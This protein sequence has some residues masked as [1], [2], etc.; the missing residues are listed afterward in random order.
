M[1]N[2]LVILDA[3]V[4]LIFPE[5]L[6]FDF[7]TSRRSYKRAFADQPVDPAT[8]EKLVDVA[9]FAPSA[10]NAQPWH[11]IAVLDADLRQKLAKAMGERFRKDLTQDGVPPREVS[12]RIHHSILTFSNA[13]ALVV[14]CGCTECT[15]DAYPDGPRQLAEGI[16]FTQSVANATCYFLLAA[17]AHGLATS[18]Y[19][20]PLFA[21]ETVREVL[22]LL[23]T[24]EPQAFVTLGYPCG[25]LPAAPP[26]KDASEIL[27]IM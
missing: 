7:L 4:F 6:G 10:H 9:Q 18:W 21:K 26:R 14:I 19:C 8:I 1:K 20:A 22:K 3:E 24:L 15:L 13:P 11:F 2:L 23:P 27:T 16:M 12:A 17:H 25:D 5:E